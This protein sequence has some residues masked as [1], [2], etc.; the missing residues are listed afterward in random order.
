MEGGR[1]KGQEGSMAGG[2]NRCRHRPFLGP[3]PPGLPNAT[4]PQPPTH[5]RSLWWLHHPPTKKHSELRF[6]TPRTLP[7]Y[8]GS[9]PFVVEVP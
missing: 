3:L 9:Y 2:R 6:P 5:Y 8:D 7:N 4:P 1:K